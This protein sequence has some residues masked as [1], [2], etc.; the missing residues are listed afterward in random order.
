MIAKYE[1]LVANESVP[2]LILYCR[3][4]HLNLLLEDY[5]KGITLIDYYDDGYKF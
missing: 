3:L 4:G 1:D 2:D 5:N